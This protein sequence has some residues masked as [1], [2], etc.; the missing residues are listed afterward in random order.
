MDLP[1]PPEKVP[2]AGNKPDNRSD[3]E[4]DDESENESEDESDDKSDDES[5]GESESG[6]DSGKED[7]PSPAEDESQLKLEED[8]DSE[9]EAPETASEAS[10]QACCNVG[11]EITG[12][13]DNFNQVPQVSDESNKAEVKITVALRSTSENKAVKRTRSPSAEAVSDKDQSLVADESKTRPE[14]SPKHKRL[15]VC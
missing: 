8:S 4:S 3:D 14:G 13:S 5:D 6:P 2:G 11:M 9:E 7:E 1:S 10:D 12:V 15:K